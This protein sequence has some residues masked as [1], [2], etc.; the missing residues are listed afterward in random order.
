MS[1][2]SRAAI[3]DVGW[4]LVL[5]SGLSIS[6]ADPAAGA[7]KHRAE[8]AMYLSMLESV[9][10]LVVAMFSRHAE[11]EFG[12]IHGAAVLMFADDFCG[13]RKL[14]GKLEMP[15]IVELRTGQRRIWTLRI[16]VRHTTAAGLVEM[17]TD[18]TGVLDV[19]AS[20]HPALPPG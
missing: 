16:A 5:D 8:E 12:D 19:L 6:W 20:S 17:V 11:V 7:A 9:R 10:P 2:S 13:P 3:G 4:T 14:K 1:G 18:A 15:C